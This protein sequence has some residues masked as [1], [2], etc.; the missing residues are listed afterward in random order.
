MKEG[1]IKREVVKSVAGGHARTKSIC[2]ITLRNGSIMSL[3][4]QV[5]LKRSASKYFG[6]SIDPIEL[7]TL[8][9]VVV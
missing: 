2:V 5:S 9:I 7:Q 1:L 4:T 3:M 6:D 8:G